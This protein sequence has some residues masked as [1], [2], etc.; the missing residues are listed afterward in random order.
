MCNTIGLSAQQRMY[1]PK[2]LS[3]IE[4]IFHFECRM[5]LLESSISEEL[6]S[7]GG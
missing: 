1:F 5:Y 6:E 2:D 3:L 4:A 7:P